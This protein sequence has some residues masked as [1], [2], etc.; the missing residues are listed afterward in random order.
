LFCAVKHFQIQHHPLA[1]LVL[2]T[3]DKM[4]QQPSNFEVKSCFGLEILNMGI[5][6]PQ[7]L[8]TQL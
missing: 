6:S 8:G 2:V 1:F 4:A 7:I 3:E 5:V